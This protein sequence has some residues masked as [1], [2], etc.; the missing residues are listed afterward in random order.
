MIDHHALARA[1]E[2]EKRG[3]RLF[4]PPQFGLAALEVVQHHQ[5]VRRKGFRAGAP[6]FFRDAHLE[7]ARVSRILRSSGVVPRQLW[8]FWPVM[9]RT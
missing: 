9:I 1:H 4:S 5:V 7:L 8:P 2:V 3:I 6:E